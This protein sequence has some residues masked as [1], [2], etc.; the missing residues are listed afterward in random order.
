MRL[1]EQIN[2]NMYRNVIEEGKRMCEKFFSLNNLSRKFTL[3]VVF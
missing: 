1:K 2:N 3:S